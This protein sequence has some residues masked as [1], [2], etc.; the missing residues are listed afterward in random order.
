ML[1]LVTFRVPYITPTEYSA[2]TIWSMYAGVGVIFGL[3][4][5]SKHRL[6]VHGCRTIIVH[7]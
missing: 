6:F 4:S 5:L 3:P 2:N 7:L 1:L